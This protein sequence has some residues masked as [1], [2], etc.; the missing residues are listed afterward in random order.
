[1]T[2]AP[3]SSSFAPDLPFKFVAGD[4]AV[5]LVNTVDWT[6]AGLAEDRL[7]DYDRLTRWAEGAG[8]L[9]PRL[10]AQFRAAAARR[11][12]A[13]ESALRAAKQLRWNLRQIFLAVAR[14][15]SP[16]KQ[17]EL[18]ELNELLT[19]A[20]SQL[21]LVDATGRGEDGPALQ[22]SW[23][24][25]SERLDSILWPVARAAAELLVSDEAE[26]IRECGGV[27]CGWMYVDRSRNGLRRWCE[28]ESCGTREKSRRRA[29]RRV[30][31]R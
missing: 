8:L 16:A 20:L 29:R 9:V 7:S 30:A 24:D 12:R 10:G 19:I 4:P 15:D 17:A 3:R 11:P 21:Q 26:R 28:M 23:R 31:D 6:S 18:A 27:D 2:T 14:G 1:M 13:A 22:W 25:A 5:D